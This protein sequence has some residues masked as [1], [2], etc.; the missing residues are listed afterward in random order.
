MGVQL[1]IMLDET[2]EEKEE[3][4]AKGNFKVDQISEHASRIVTS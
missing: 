3:E 4:S 1:S 2:G